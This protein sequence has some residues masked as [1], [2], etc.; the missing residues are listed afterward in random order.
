MRLFSRNRPHH[1]SERRRDLIVAAV[2]VVTVV[3]GLVIAGTVYIAP[4]GQKVYSAQLVNTGGLES[5][6][7]VRIAGIRQGTVSSVDLAGT[8]ITVEFR[9]DDSVPVRS[10]A[11]AAVRLITPIGGRVLDLDP[12]SGPTSLSGAI[13]LVQTSS[14][15]DISDTLETTTPVFRDVKGVDL[16]QT[17]S[18][19]Q[20]AFSDGNTNIADAL[21]NTSSLMELLERQYGQLDK[22][23]ALSDEYV[24]AFADQKQ[25]LVDFLRQL[26]FLASTLGPDIDNVRGG[27][28]L[29]SR[30]FKLLTRPLVAYSDGIEPSVQQY[31]TLLDKVSSEL[32]GYSDA[33]AQVDQITQRLGVLLQAPVGASTTTEPEVRVC[34]PSGDDKC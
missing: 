4:P 25:V 10:D 32:P 2:V 34:I 9:L 5:G 17:A 22:A 12:G 20:N 33:L 28:D 16:R 13:P 6:D 23:V 31:K 7:Q 15:Y 19:L 8:F 26:S 18:L 27:F 11:T 29:L 1:Q 30:L 3:V 14:T 21:R 24:N